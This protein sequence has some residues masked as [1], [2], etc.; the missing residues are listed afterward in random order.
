MLRGPYWVGDE[1]MNGLF[2]KMQRA[3]QASGTLLFSTFFYDN[4]LRK[5]SLAELRRMYS[6]AKLGADLWTWERCL[7]PV[8]VNSGSHWA[9]VNVDLVSKEL[10]FVD[11]QGAGGRYVLVS[12]AGPDAPRVLLRLADFSCS[13]FS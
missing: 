4:L 12:V 10:S 8:N 9:L 2:A 1:V 11:S 5:K 3:L 7:F 6:Q 13:S